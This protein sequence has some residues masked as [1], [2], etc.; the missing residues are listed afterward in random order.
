MIKVY[1]WLIKIIA[2]SVLGSI[3]ASWFQNTL[4]GIWFYAKVEEI[5]NWAAERYNIEQLKTTDSFYK[6]YPEIAQRLDRI[7]KQLKK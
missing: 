7:E 1:Y 4:T 5:M 2:G 6:K 3:F